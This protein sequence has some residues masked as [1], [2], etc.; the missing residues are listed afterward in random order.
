VTPKLVLMAPHVDRDWHDRRNCVTVATNI[1]NS[2]QLY[3]ACGTGSIIHS[4][5]CRP[6]SWLWPNLRKNLW[7]CH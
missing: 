4:A 1:E 6:V 3:S 5:D 7:F 2:M